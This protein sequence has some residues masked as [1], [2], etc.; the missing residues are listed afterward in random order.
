MVQGDTFCAP[1]TPPINSA[2]AVIR[3]SGPLSHSVMKKVFQCKGE[4]RERYAHYGSI[5]SDEA[6]ID[7][8]I[9][10]FYRSPR[11]FTGEDMV[12]IFCHG[13]HMVVQKIMR[14]LKRMGIR[15]AEPGEFSKTAFVN[16]K[17][18]LTE[19]EG[20][21]HLINARSEWEIETALQQM[22]GSFHR[23]LSKI[24]DQIIHLKADIECG[25]DF[26]EEDLSIV[27][28]DAAVERL[29][30]IKEAI[31]DV[32]LRCRIGSQLCHGIDVTITG[33]PNVGKSSILNLVLNRERAIVSD[34]PG[35]TRDII[36]EPVQIGGIH[37]NIID[38]AGID[39]PA[40]EVERLGIERSVQNI[41]GSAL[42]LVVFDA[43]NGFQQAD[44]NIIDKVKNKKCIYII[45]KADI[46][47]IGKVAAIKTRI[48]SDA[49]MF[50][51]ITGMGLKELENVIKVYIDNHFSDLHNS[52][53]AD[54]RVISLLEGALEIVSKI[55]ALY[56]SSEPEIIVI[57]EFEA[58]MDTVSE[59]IGE[60]APD[61]ILDSIF[62]RFCIGK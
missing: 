31:R 13:N 56:R 19:A 55:E 18:N 23:A 58:L 60:I 8:I 47:D 48:G 30:K 53:I 15:Y 40:N 14:L 28:T 12:E 62:S 61:D 35:T 4:I 54:V 10:I 25:I 24:R 44:G 33:K 49:L 46:A 29:R 45:N 34:I 41:E 17:M 7:D 52:F 36:R 32:L 38:T 3:V 2:I 1:A 21:N 22:H 20:V 51:A 6:I 11:S 57:S 43:S 27:S 37:L 42:I 16:G 59:I 39:T 50:S 5:F 26:I 9:A